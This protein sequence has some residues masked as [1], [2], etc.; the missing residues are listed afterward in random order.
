MPAA[1]TAR[2]VAELSLQD[3]FS[4]G[5]KGVLG[6][7]DKAESRF[8]SIGQKASAGVA[9]FSKNAALIGVGVAGALA[10]QVV[11]GVK[12]L[13]QLETVLN[14]TA[15]VIKSTGGAAGVSA[16]QVRDLAQ[17]LEETTTVDDKAIQGGEN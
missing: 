13:E 7:L 11:A 1:D 10:T 3:S 6:S 8:G 16:K 4:K 9:N 17:S 2:L 5:M 14:A 12:S 15:G